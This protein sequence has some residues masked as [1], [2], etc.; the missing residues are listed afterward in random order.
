M[1]PLQQPC[2][3]PDLIEDI[4]DVTTSE[5]VSKDPQVVGKVCEGCS[6]LTE[7]LSRLQESNRKLKPRHVKLP[8]DVKHTV[9]RHSKISEVYN[10]YNYDRYIY[11]ST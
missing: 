10:I 8:Q 3:V 2:S 11:R 4:K 1:S 7:R 6:A 9:Q 5:T